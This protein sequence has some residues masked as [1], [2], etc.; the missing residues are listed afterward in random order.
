[1]SNQRLIEH[2]TLTLD[3]Y[4]SLVHA[5]SETGRRIPDSVAKTHR[6]LEDNKFLLAVVGKVKAGKSTFINALLAQD[7]L[8]TDFLQAT[9]AIIEISHS[10]TPFLRV[11]YADGH[12]EEINANGAE[13]PLEPLIARLREVSAIA[14]DQRDIPFAQLN[15]FIIDHLADGTSW[16]ED[17]LSAFIDVDLP[18]ILN[19]PPGE[20]QQKSRDYLAEH[21]HGR[22]IA[23]TIEVGYPTNFKFEHFRIVDTPGI[24]AKGGFDLRTHAFLSKAD[25]VIYLHKE[26]PSET[27]LHNNLELV[28]PEKVKKHLL[29]VFTHRSSRS[30]EDNQRFFNEAVRTCPSIS[31]G[32]IFLVDSL[33]DR[34]LESFYD[35]KTWSDIANFRKID[36][37]KH[38]DLRK[39]TASAFE[40]AEGDRSRLLD[41]LEAQSNM[42]LL[43]ESVFRLSENS[44][45]IQINTLL[46]AI[47]RLYAEIEADEAGMC[48]IHGLK[49]KDPQMFSAEMARQR[50]KMD[51]LEAETKMRMSDIRKKYDLQKSS[52]NGFGSRLNKTISR[53][54]EEVNGKYFSGESATETENYLHRIK[55]DLDHALEQLTEDMRNAFKAEI[56]SMQITMDANYEMLTVPNIP[57]PEILEQV[58]E[59]ATEEHSVRKAKEGF[60]N[61][62]KRFFNA[63][64]GWTIESYRALNAEN[65]FNWAKSDFL[66]RLPD[67]K[68]NLI[69]QVNPVITKATEE[70]TR[71]M[72]DKLNDRRSK[73][74]ELEEDRKNNDLVREQYEAHSRRMEEA[75]SKKEECDRIKSLL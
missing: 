58:R 59:R 62:I 1:M 32:R 23:K 60:F 22:D 9:A 64:G 47:R 4:R 33:T 75:R 72:N 39:V 38:K 53:F 31:P 46:E 55:Q 45:K 27:S 28:I 52:G 42:R 48:E 74:R 49:L 35:L 43:K 16:D 25:A 17:K 67:M 6:N 7:I 11:T 8:P 10:T 69:D 18:N 29:L 40:E 66:Q 34:A 68:I 44:L 71:V 41:I 26:E 13:D 21:K 20:W 3:I 50:N 51:E 14:S 15:D 24:C 56:E 65:Y 73:I 19:E 54:E 36:S 70:Y 57:L 5:V 12:T 61:S 63:E 37:K 30:D 2:K